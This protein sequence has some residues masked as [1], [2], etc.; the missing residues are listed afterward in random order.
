MG[1]AIQWKKIAGS[2][3]VIFHQYEGIDADLV[4]SIVEHDLAPLERCLQTL[5]ERLSEVA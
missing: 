3:D 4:W 1:P 5:L 2:W